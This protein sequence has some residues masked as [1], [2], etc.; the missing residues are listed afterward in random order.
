MSGQVILTVL[1]LGLCP[2]GEIP[3]AGGFLQWSYRRRH[4]T[5]YVP[6]QVTG[7]LTLAQR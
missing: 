3:E 6:S 4:I 2:V 5:C 7:S 1:L